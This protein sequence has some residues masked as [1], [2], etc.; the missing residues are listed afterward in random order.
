[1][2]VSA[3]ALHVLKHKAYARDVQEGRCWYTV[4]WLRD[5]LTAL[6]RQMHE[7]AKDELAEYTRS[8]GD[9]EFKGKEDKIREK[10]ILDKQNVQAKV[11]E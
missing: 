10:K 6:Q 1:M 3:Y 2:S 11:T 4:G 8:L 7:L 5:E 9:K